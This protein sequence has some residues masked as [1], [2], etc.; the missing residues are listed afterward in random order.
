M[1][2]E[3]GCGRSPIPGGGRDSPSLVP[4]RGPRPHTF[5]G[6]V[7]VT[8]RGG[9]DA[10][11][12]GPRFRRCCLRTSARGSPGGRCR[13]PVILHGSHEEELSDRTATRCSRCIPVLPVHPSAPSV[14]RAPGASLCSQGSQCSRCIPVLLLLPGHPGVP[15]G[16]PR[17]PITSQCSQCSWFTSALH[18]H[19]QG[20]ALGML[21]GVQAA[22]PRGWQEPS[23]IPSPVL[24]PRVLTSPPLPSSGKPPR[25][26]WIQA[27]VLP[28]P[29]GSCSGSCLAPLPRGSP[30]PAPVRWDSGETR[31]IAAESAGTRDAGAAPR[32]VP[33]PAQ[34][35]SP[36]AVVLPARTGIEV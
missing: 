34:K 2:S 14:P 22:A 28:E 13:Y 26:G 16:V 32:R 27:G 19:P 17:V 25:K 33:A 20:C 24:T 30:W 29:P 21:E 8:P 10:P 5:P 18:T 31:D 12:R 36:T 9:R 1:G 3:P 35:S 7:A 11:C 4:P 6:A 15:P 23:S